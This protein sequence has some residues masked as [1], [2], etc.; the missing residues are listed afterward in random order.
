M[1]KRTSVYIPKMKEHDVF[2]KD[3]SY[4]IKKQRGRDSL[5]QQ[6]EQFTRG[7]SGV[8]RTIPLVDDDSSGK[9]KIRREE[10]TR[11]KMVRG[12]A[13]VLVGRCYQLYNYPYKRISLASLYLCV[14]YYTR[15]RQLEK[16][17]GKIVI[18]IWSRDR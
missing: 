6:I 11:A 18:L 3:E 12:I 7:L 13:G 17:R 4:E 5:A 10:G 2:C 15:T 16:E 14:R 9:P 1:K 8:R